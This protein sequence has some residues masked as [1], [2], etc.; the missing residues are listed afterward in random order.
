MVDRKYF[1]SMSG[2]FR[3]FLHGSITPE[4][5][6]VGHFVFGPHKDCMGEVSVPAFVM[7]HN[8]EKPRWVQEADYVD[9]GS[10]DKPVL[11]EWKKFLASLKEAYNN[12]RIKWTDGINY[13]AKIKPIIEAGFDVYWDGKWRTASEFGY[14]VDA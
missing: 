11:E 3:S 5:L 1:V 8:I 4:D 2:T 14:M 7:S 9:A 6:Q 13:P 10:L 12:E